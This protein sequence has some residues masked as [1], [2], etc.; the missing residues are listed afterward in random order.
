MNGSQIVDAFNNFGTSGLS[1]RHN[2]DITKHVAAKSVVKVLACKVVT[3]S[4]T[5]NLVVTMRG[6]FLSFSLVLVFELEHGLPVS[7]G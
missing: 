1:Y 7:Q 6:G 2:I 3:G 4:N 5:G